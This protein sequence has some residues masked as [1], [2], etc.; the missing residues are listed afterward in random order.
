MTGIVAWLIAEFLAGMA[1][2]YW[3]V[4]REEAKFF[5]AWSHLLMQQPVANTQPPTMIEHHGEWWP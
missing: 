3:V 1:I 2:G 4:R 5:R